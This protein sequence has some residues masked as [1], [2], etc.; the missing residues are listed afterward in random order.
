MIHP[1][2]PDSWVRVKLREER[3]WPGFV[4]TKLLCR[5]RELSCACSY[6]PMLEV[7]A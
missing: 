4:S 1:D 6:R 5:Q 2:D 7:F 3:V